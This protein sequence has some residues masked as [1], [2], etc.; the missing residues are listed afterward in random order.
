MYSTTPRALDY[1][2]FELT[3]CVSFEITDECVR[4]A[5]NRKLELLLV[6]IDPD[7][8]SPSCV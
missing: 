4:L 2:E 5:G 1:T 6:Y 8:D 3:R 7:D